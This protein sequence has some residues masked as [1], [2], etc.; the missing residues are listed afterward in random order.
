[1]VLIISPSSHHYTLWTNLH[2]S[3]KHCP[4]VMTYFIPGHLCAKLHYPHPESC[5][6]LFKVYLALTSPYLF[7]FMSMQSENKIPLMKES[8][9]LISALSRETKTRLSGFTFWVYHFLSLFS[10]ASYLNF[11]YVSYFICKMRIIIGS[12]Y[13]EIK[14]AHVKQNSVCCLISTI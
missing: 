1:M 9:A 12:Y 11:L 6:K 14:W 3:P 5:N 2:S 8:R 4:V 7:P 10:G 13:I